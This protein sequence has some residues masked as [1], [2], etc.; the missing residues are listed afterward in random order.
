MI[1]KKIQILLVVYWCLSINSFLE[2]RQRQEVLCWWP[3]APDH[4][5]GTVGVRSEA[6]QVPASVLPFLLALAHC[7]KSF[8]RKGRK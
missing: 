7:D 8:P 4:R 1:P 2:G 5:K 3:V 6:G